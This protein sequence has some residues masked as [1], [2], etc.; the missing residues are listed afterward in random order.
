MEIVC[1]WVQLLGKAVSSEDGAASLFDKHRIQ[2]IKITKKKKYHLMSSGIARG[3]LA[4]VGLKL[5][6]NLFNVV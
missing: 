4:E 1:G 6:F 3:R 2:G 5:I